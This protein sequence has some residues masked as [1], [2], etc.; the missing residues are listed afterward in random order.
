MYSVFEEGNGN[1]FQ[2]SSLENSVDRE[3][4]WAAVHGVAQSQTRLKRL[5]MLA[6]IGQGNG[7]PL[8]YSCL[9]NPWDRGAWWA[10]VYGVAQSWTRLKRLSSSR[11]IGASQVVGD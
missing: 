5:S 6:Y 9:E 4:W 7:N 8:Q 3:A 2:Y 10:A 11:S 1:P